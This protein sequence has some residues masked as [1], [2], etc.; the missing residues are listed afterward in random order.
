MLNNFLHPFMS[1][2]ANHSESLAF[3]LTLTINGTAHKIPGANIKQCE[4]QAYSYGFSGAVGFY[5]PDEQR[6]D[7]LLPEFTAESLI[8]IELGIKA[9]HNLPKPAPDA[10]VVKGLVTKKSLTEL[11]Y[12]QVSGNPVLYRYYQIHFADPAQVLWKQHYPSELLVKDCMAS[13]IKM[14][15]VPPIN[16]TINFPPADEVQP[17]ISLVLGN[18]EYI[19]P[20]ETGVSNNASFYDFLIDYCA[21]ENAFFIYDYERQHYLLQADAP[22]PKSTQPFLPHEISTLHQHWPSSRRSIT[23]LLNG[24]ALGSKK[25]TVKNSNA[26][27]GINHDILLRHNIDHRFATRTSK[28]SDKKMDH[29]E[30]ID[31]H[32]RQWPLQT[33]WPHCQFQINANVNGK[34]AFHADKSYCS[35]TCLISATAIDCTPEHNLDLHFTQYKLTYRMIGHKTDAPVSVLP[36]YKKPTYPLYVEGLVVSDVGAADEKTFDVPRNDQTGQFEYKVHIPLWDKTIPI[37]LEPDFLN[38]HFYFPFY[39]NTRLL[40]GLDLYRAHI[41][42]VL[43]WGDGVQMPQITQ[44]NHI[45][46]GKKTNDE[47]SLSHAYEN[48]KPVFAIKRKKEKDTELLRMEEGSIIFQT[49]EEP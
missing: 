37:L 46:F 49:C 26:V 8:N 7:E 14:Q 23:N 20:G 28:E 40:I 6:Q 41:Y 25:N 15:V 17:L 5:L 18:T 4:L 31:V 43:S 13:A 48:S 19:S 44:G 38:S 21:R 36:D 16:L 11:S 22:E 10:F 2:E 47:T 45:L 30:Q 12:E 1:P 34:H 9:V 29:G 27:T 39:R 3:S 33:F 24:V 42:K 32:F 35:D